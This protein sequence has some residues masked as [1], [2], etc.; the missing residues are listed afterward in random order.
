MGGGA[1]KGQ[2]G[3]STVAT[4]EIARLRWDG[5]LVAGVDLPAP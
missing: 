3:A 4:T 1:R 5:A 2:T